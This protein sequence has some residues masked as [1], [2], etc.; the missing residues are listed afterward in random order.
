MKRACVVLGGDRDNVRIE[1]YD[2][3]IC[4]DSG[5][6][7]LRKGDRPTHL[8]G[9]MDSIGASALKEAVSSGIIL[10]IHP[11]EKD[12][13]DG[14]AAVMTAISE[15]ADD[16]TIEGTFG[17]RSDH[18]LSTFHIL[19]LIPRGIASRIRLGKDVISLIRG[20]E[21]VTIEE[22]PRVISLIPASTGTTV[23]TEGLKYA[24]R[25][26]KLD[27]GSTRGIHNEPSSERPSLTVHSGSVYLVL[28]G[29]ADSEW[30]ERGVDTSPRPISPKERP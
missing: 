7:R 20:G 14:E 4:A 6:E 24:L 16:I 25:C 17:D 23:T 10:S 2:L 21:K 28:S 26:E 29:D 8:V 13:S 12:L 18:L 19:H 3:V 5:Y 27:L 9:D 22:P 30:A 11:K 1:G 15:G